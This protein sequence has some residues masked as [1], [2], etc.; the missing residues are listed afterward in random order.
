[1]EHC[2]Q[3][4]P[5]RPTPLALPTG[6]PPA[7]PYGHSF[8]PPTSGCGRTHDALHRRRNETRSS[9]WVIW[10]RKY[11]ILCLVCGGS[12]V[13]VG[14]LF[15]AI[16]FTLRSYTS[17]L[18]FFETIPT[19]V[20][21]AV[22]IATGLMV[23]CFAKRRNR[24]TYLVKFAGGCCLT[25]VLL[26]VVIT[27]TTT[28]V[29]MNRLQTLHKCDYSSK[30]KA[31]MCLSAIGD[32]AAQEGE[33]QLVFNNTPNCDVVHGSLYGCLRALFG[34]SV[35]GILV[36]IF[37]SMLIYQLLSHERKKL[38]LEQLELRR[39][40]LYRRHPSHAFCACYDDMCHS[41][42]PL[43]DVVDCHFLASPQLT[44]S[45]G[46]EESR[47][48]GRARASQRRGWLPWGRS[49]RPRAPHDTRRTVVDRLL[50]RDGWHNSTGS[51]TPSPLDAPASPWRP[52][53][54]DSR[55]VHRRTR[56]ND[57]VFHHLQ[58]H[59]PRLSFPDAPYTDL[60]GYL[61]GPPPPYSQPPSL[62]DVT[63]VGVEREL[64]VRHADEQATLDDMENSPRSSKMSTPVPE[65]HMV[66]TMGGEYAGTCTQEVHDG[67]KR[68]RAPCIVEVPCFLHKGSLLFN[69]LPARSCRKGQPSPFKSLSNIPL[70]ISR[71]LSLLRHENLR[72][73]GGFSFLRYEAKR[74]DSTVLP[75]TY[76][77]ICER[78]LPVKQGSVE[79]SSNNMSV[80]TETTPT[81]IT[82]PSETTPVIGAVIKMVHARS[83]PNLSVS[84]SSAKGAEQASQSCTTCTWSS[85]D[86]ASVEHDDA[87]E[88]G[89]PLSD[90]TSA[91]SLPD[92][93]EFSVDAEHSEQQSTVSSCSHTAVPSS[94]V[95]P[96]EYQRKYV[97]LA[98]R[99]AEQS[100]P[101]FSPLP[102]VTEG[103]CAC[104]S[105]PNS[106][107]RSS[108][109]LRARGTNQGS[110]C[111]RT[112]SF[113]DGTDGFVVT[114]RSMNV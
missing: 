42:W 54:G 37:S 100:K 57:G 19:Y 17:S 81:I 92:E 63:R 101:T 16:Y 90:A 103:C 41:S 56:S 44:R 68:E 108:F 22:L 109:T 1:M 85:R 73:G 107:V 18:Q 64:E 29:H 14:V 49:R 45:H 33:H 8:L 72:N 21:A 93:E 52:P 38:Y 84:L 79:E 88:D 66:L 69:T 95:V 110:F 77:V 111:P 40:L 36:C 71:R 31:C 91:P 59:P 5:N 105:Q 9:L 7:L 13:F 6:L 65:R 78:A 87:S 74:E 61:W 114:F 53:R 102:F 75:G 89:S 28:V 3:Q 10:L 83:M 67:S 47:P 27:V 94:S 106:E 62:E 48:R 60:P 11:V 25:C 35:V 2:Q 82:L 51:H 50:V 24:Y 26:C 104:P 86:F 98:R 32:A 55:G 99:H 4:T 96:A 43:W 39:R 58:M 112:K 30:D 46:L 23:M 76:G 20:P 15:I 113:G 34:L 70:C 80:P 97:V 12:A